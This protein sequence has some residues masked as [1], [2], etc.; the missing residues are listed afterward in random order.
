MFNDSLPPSK[1]LKTNGNT[2]VAFEESRELTHAELWDDSVLIDAWEA[3]HEEYAAYHGG[4]IALK[5]NPTK[6]SPLWYN[7]PFDDSKIKENV[8]EYSSSLEEDDDEAADQ[9]YDD[10]ADHGDSKPINFDTFVPSHDASLDVGD[11]PVIAPSSSSLPAPPAETVSQDEAFT[12]AV[13]AMYWA[14][15]WTAMY[16][17]QRNDDEDQVEGMVSDIVSTQR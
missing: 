5:T 13:N 15:Y 17:C 3:V 1:K 14:G 6:R 8:T 2:T 4:D 12:R 9:D 16:Q 7:I 10:E 11:D